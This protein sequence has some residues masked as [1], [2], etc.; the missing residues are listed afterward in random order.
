MVKGLKSTLAVGVVSLGAITPAYAAA[1]VVSGLPDVRVGDGESYNSETSTDGNVFTFE[2]AFQFSQKVHDPDTPSNLLKWSFGQGND[3]PELPGV[4]YEINNVG[5]VNPDDAAIA[6][7]QAAGYPA[8][9]APGDKQINVGPDADWA[10]FRDIIFS[11]TAGSAPY[12]APDPVKAAAAAE[13]RTLEFYVSDPEGNVGVQRVIVKT[14]DNITDL[15]EGTDGYQEEVRDTDFSS[16]GWTN[17]GI[18]SS[19]V[20][21]AKQPGKLTITVTPTNGR[22]RIYGWKNFGLLPYDSVGPTK[23][24]E[25]KFYIHASNPMSA[26]VNQVPGFRLRLTQEGA[27]NAAAHFEYARTGFSDPGYEPYYAQLNNPDAENKAGK[28]LRPTD[29]ATTPSLYTMNMDPVDVPAAI[30]SNL[31]ALMESYAMPDPANGTLTLSEIVLS[32]YDAKTNDDP[33]AQ[34]VYEYNRASGLA[35]GAGGPKTMGGGGF[36]HEADFQPGRR[37]DLYLPWIDGGTYSTST[38]SNGLL[39]DTAGISDNI[40]GIGV[41]NVTQNDPAQR[42]RIEPNKLYRAMFYATAPVPTQSFDNSKPAQG[43]LRFRF[44][45]AAGTLSHLLEVASV[46]GFSLGSAKANQIAKEALPGIGGANPDQDASLNTP[47]EAGGWYSVLVSSP[48]NVDGI[49]VNENNNFSTLAAEPGPG[50]AAANSARDVVLGVDLVKMPKT[51]RTDPTTVINYA[52]PNRA[53]VRVSA[54]K[55]YEYPAIDDGGYDFGQ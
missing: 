36:N 35:N 31:G 3:K 7:D 52:R 14:V 50:A 21:A 42:L 16:P 53:V 4:Q 1:P 23:F 32:T 5:P 46:Q 6:A 45:T 39:A 48:L 12:P 29:S 11:P 33:D 20:S 47:Q 17:S 44:Q 43:N 28:W 49:R 2:K 54:I 8:A 34:L 15:T 13:G 24:V 25:G 27:V 18:A 38:D 9:A 30:G 40:Y 51:L 55:V 19:G 22:Y 37:Q 26:P 10:T 41:M